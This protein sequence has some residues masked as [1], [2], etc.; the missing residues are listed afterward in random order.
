VHELKI[1]VRLLLLAGLLFLIQLRFAS[2]LVAYYAT[3]IIEPHTP[4]TYS[5]SATGG[6]M[7]VGDGTLNWGSSTGTISFWIKWNV[8]ANRPWGQHDNMETRFTGTNLILDW[9]AANSLTSSTSFVAGKWYFIAIVWNQ[10]TNR[11]YLYVG[12]QVTSPTLDSVN[13]AWTS[14]VSTV[15]VTQNNFLASKGGVNPTDGYGDDLRYW[16]TDRAL[17][18]IQSDYKIEI[19]GSEANLRSYFKLD[20]SFVDAGPNHND[21]SGVGSYLFS[22]DAPFMP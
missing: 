9:G 11:L 8:V 16:N 18:A 20:N 2:S 14:S 12:D 3:V 1:Q 4:N 5:L 7:I 13:N 15:G 17:A 21:G 10:N 19:T 22:T 6:Y